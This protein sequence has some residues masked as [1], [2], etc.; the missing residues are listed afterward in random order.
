MSS[1]DHENLFASGPHTFRVGGLSLRHALQETPG[2][3]GVQLSALGHYGRAIEQSGTLIADSPAALR[4]LAAA[5]EAKL[6]GVAH[7]LVDDVS[8]AWPDVV[9][10]SFDPGAVTPLGRRFGLG[11]RIQYLQVKP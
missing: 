11:Y 6:D 7:E 5:I 8:R 10:L 1:F 9:M 2:S 3:R 4:T